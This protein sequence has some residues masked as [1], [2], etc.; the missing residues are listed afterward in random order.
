MLLRLAYEVQHRLPFNISPSTVPD[1][2]LVQLVEGPG[3]LPP[4]RA[5][6]LGCGPGRN[7]VYLA[8][9][10]WDVTGVELVGHAVRRARRRAADARVAV[11]FLHGD[12]TKLSELGVGGGYSLVVDAGCYHALPVELRA[13]YVREV[14]AAAAPGALMI[15]IAFEQQNTKG[16]DV[17]EDEVASAFTGWEITSRAAVPVAEIV[18]YVDGPAF[19]KRPLVNGTYRARRYEL[20][21][22]TTSA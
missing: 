13:D 9:N 12:V 14:T 21:R 16:W 4:G 5:L 18:R 7:S 6:D 17:S 20:R 19:A 22:S 1:D 11:R 8:R 3:A 10:G 15:L 2:R